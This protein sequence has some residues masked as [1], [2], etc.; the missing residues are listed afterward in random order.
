MKSLFSKLN[1]F[2][3]VTLKTLL[4]AI[5]STKCFLRRNRHLFLDKNIV[6][7]LLNH[8]SFVVVKKQATKNLYLEVSRS[9]GY[10]MNTMRN[11]SQKH[12]EGRRMYF[13]PSLICF[14][15]FALLLKLSHVNCLKNI[16]FSY[17]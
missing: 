9:D 3:E 7:A 4:Q 1:S 2:V 6:E 10:F 14:V 5:S 8:V 12:Y 13:V 16:G 17:P 15:F 11:F